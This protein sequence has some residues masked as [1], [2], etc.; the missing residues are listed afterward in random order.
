MTIAT[1][2][3]PGL[4]V[5]NWSLGGV[6]ILPLLIKLGGS[7]V[8][9][10]SKISLRVFPTGLKNTEAGKVTAAAWRGVFRLIPYVVDPAAFARDCITWASVDGIVDGVFRLD[11]VI[12]DLDGSGKALSMEPQFLQGISYAKPNMQSIYL[13]HMRRA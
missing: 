13:K 6:N 8:K 4:S 10:D 5:T 11:E 1:D 2:S 3:E 12:L 9:S 7:D